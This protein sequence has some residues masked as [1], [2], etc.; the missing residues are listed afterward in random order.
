[1][2]LDASEILGSQ[3]LAGV[4]VNPRGMGKAVGARYGGMYGGLAGA[5]V[6]AARSMKA[7]EEKIA[8]REESETPTFGRLAYFVVTPEEVALVE[9]KSKIVT[10]YLDQVIARVRRGEVASIELDGGGAGSC[11]LTVTFTS[12]DAWELEVP[13]PSKKYAKRVVE[14]LGG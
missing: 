9:L 6:G 12:G 2:A 4:K 10:V 7:N 11:P 5:A 3:Q 14:Q 1:M 8:F 13:K